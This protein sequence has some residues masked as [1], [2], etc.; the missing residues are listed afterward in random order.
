MLLIY[1]T[2]FLDEKVILSILVSGNRSKIL[3]AMKEYGDNLVKQV[4]ITHRD[5]LNTGVVNMLENLLKIQLFIDGGDIEGDA[6]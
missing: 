3:D 5:E 1:T 6:E 2:T 4:A